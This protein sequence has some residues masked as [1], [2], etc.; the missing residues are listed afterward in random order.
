MKVV[1]SWSL[2]SNFL[3]IK[4]IVNCMKGLLN[5]STCSRS[6]LMVSGEV[7]KSACYVRKNK[8]TLI[9]I[10]TKGHL[11]NFIKWAIRNFQIS[12]PFLHVLHDKNNT[13]IF[14]NDRTA[15]IIFQSFF[16]HSETCIMTLGI[17]CFKER[18]FENYFTPVWVEWIKRE[19]DIWET[20]VHLF[21][22]FC[23]HTL[24]VTVLNS[25]QIQICI[26]NTFLLIFIWI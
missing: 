13:E 1:R 25:V 3:L 10:L 5:S 20:R 11:E 7:D 16:S 6:E 15:L 26:W 22:F 12:H 14:L 9:V 21:T 4:L 18:F 24:K 19:N 17:Y 23:S 8:I 2:V